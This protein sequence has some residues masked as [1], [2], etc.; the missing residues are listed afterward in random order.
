MNRRP[1]QRPRVARV[2]RQAVP[3]DVHGRDALPKKTARAGFLA[4]KTALATRSDA[5][6]RPRAARGRRDRA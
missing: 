1:A 4:A 6:P 3:A 2:H 5:R